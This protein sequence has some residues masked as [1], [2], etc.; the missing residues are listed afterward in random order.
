LIT[1]IGGFDITAHT[2]PE[3]LFALVLM[4]FGLCFYSFV[5][6]NI[7]SMLSAIDIREEKFTVM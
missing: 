1:T 5:I 4:L 3:R 6:G 7:A 2:I